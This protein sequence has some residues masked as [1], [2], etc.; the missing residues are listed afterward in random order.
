MGKLKI[1]KAKMLA[2]I[3]DR[4]RFGYRKYGIPQSGAMDIQSLNQANELV[5]NPKDYPGV[6][7]SLQGLTL[8]ALEPTAIGICGGEVDMKI[9][10]DEV[11]MNHAHQL[12]PGDELIVSPLRKGVY[13]YLAISG[14]I[15]G[16][17]DFKSI[18]TYVLAGF[19]GIT[20]KPLQPGDVLIT[21]DAP[22]FTEKV[23]NPSLASEKLPC[24]RYL[25]GP[26][27]FALK[28]ELDGVNFM[29]GKESNRMGILLNGPTI[30]SSVKE[31]VSSGVIPGTIQL[32]PNGSP[33]VL[34]NDGQTTGGYPRIGKV[35]DK[36]LGKLAQ[37]RPGH[38]I[39]ML[40]AS[41]S[42]AIAAS[43]NK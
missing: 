18:S 29:V 35:I 10:Q 15:Q 26:E 38:S 41:I 27:T 31:I 33:V 20:G 11:K 3:Q 7:I 4:G 24:I 22:L 39:V 1:V 37:V 13:S 34:M 43:L 17:Y 8:K 6:E 16:Q 32:L 19:G 23:A 40:K 42:E 28:S 21:E 14:K 30:E 12:L 25:E 36:D 9:N 5:C 2:T